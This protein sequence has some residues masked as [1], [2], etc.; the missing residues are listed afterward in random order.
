MTFQRIFRTMLAIAT[1]AAISFSVQAMAQDAGP[2]GRHRMGRG[3]FGK[4]LNLSDA[5]KSQLKAMKEKFKTD[6]SSSVKE[7][8]ALRDQMRQLRQSGST[9]KEAFKALR[10]K[11]KAEATK[12]RQAR[13][14]MRDQMKGV[15]TPEQLEELKKLKDHRRGPNGGEIEPKDGKDSDVK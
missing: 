13:R 2:Q 9:D 4:K 8:R 3:H 1:V 5:Q 15:L 14:Q 7:L 10:E 12:L 6:N 11:M